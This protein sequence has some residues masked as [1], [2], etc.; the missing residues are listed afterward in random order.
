M[1]VQLIIFA[2]EALKGKNKQQLQN[3]EAYSN[4]ICVPL[5]FYNPTL[6]I[7]DHQVKSFPFH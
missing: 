2:K 7:E 3:T 4:K 5:L 1:F 6:V